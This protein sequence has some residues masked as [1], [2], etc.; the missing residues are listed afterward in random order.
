M[1]KK[2]KPNLHL[3][4]FYRMLIMRYLMITC[5]SNYSVD[6]RYRNGKFLLVKCKA[7]ELWVG[8]DPLNFYRAYT[9]LALI[10]SSAH[11]QLSTRKAEKH[12]NHMNAIGLVH[13]S[14]IRKSTGCARPSFVAIVFRS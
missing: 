8:E 5:G 2:V 12:H 3:V 1:R 11:A 6:L 13:C 9:T 10:F 14:C 7:K 4:E